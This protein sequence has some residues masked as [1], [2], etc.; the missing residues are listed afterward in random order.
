MSILCYQMLIYFS[1]IPLPIKSSRF[2]NP[3]QAITGSLQVGH[4]KQASHL[5][6]SVLTN[7]AAPLECMLLWQQSQRW[8]QS[9]KS[10]DSLPGVNMHFTNGSP[11]ICATC[12]AFSKRE[13][14][15]QGMQQGYQLQLI[16]APFHSILLAHLQDTTLTLPPRPLLPTFCTHCWLIDAGGNNGLWN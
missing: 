14:M 11:W 9:Q 10:C 12:F 4:L 3:G 1:L 16:S 8:L 13:G 6:C 2:P 5:G 15:D 7:V